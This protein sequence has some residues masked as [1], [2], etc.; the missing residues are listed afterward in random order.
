M[1]DEEFRREN[2]RT[3]AQTKQMLE[4]FILRYERDQLSLA[5]RYVSDKTEQKE[6]RSSIELQL[7]EVKAFMSKLTPALAAIGVIVVSVL[8]GVGLWITHWVEK[9]WN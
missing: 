6:W 1:T 5:Q 9:H 4:D 8:G 3:T 2:D 7:G